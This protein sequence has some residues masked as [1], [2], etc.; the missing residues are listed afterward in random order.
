MQ[1][2]SMF[3]RSAANLKSVQCLAVTGV[4]SALYI[5]LNAYVGLNITSPLGP[6]RITFG[7]LALAMIAMLYGPVV[8]VLAAI[9]CDLLAAT[10][11][12]HNAMNPVFTP[13]RMLEGLI[14]GI[15]LYGLLRKDY[16]GSILNMVGFVLRIAMAR[17]VVM[18]VCYIVL[19]NFLI[20]NFS[21]PP[22]RPQEI[23]SN[24]TFWAWAWA[25]NGWKNLIQFPADLALMY[26]MLPSAGLAYIK[27]VGK[28]RR[29]E[30]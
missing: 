19:N 30:A 28:H 24:G 13:N 5:V 14:Y 4:L 29:K 6:L 10:L 17:L 9:P 18:F 25:R 15:M 8:A 3:R 11:D 7:Y 27:T 23:L 21:L 1:I 16:R 12:P 22:G 26:I 20:F 2:F